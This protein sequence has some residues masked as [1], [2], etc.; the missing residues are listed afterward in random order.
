MGPS[1][2]RNRVSSGAD[3]P[4]HWPRATIFS[5]V[6]LYFINELEKSTDPDANYSLATTYSAVEVSLA[7]WAGSVPALWPLIRQGRRLGDHLGTTAR[8]NGY[9][10]SHYTSRMASG[11]V[12]T[13]GDE[14][15][16]ELAARGVADMRTECKA[17]T[18]Q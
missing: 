12:R 4:S 14:E 10:E 8:Y 2:C 16:M 15:D 18:A 7:I 3:D 13:G 6:R 9:G 17:S 11:W 5:C 1:C